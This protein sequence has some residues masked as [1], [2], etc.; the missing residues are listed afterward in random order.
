MAGKNEK[1]VVDAVHAAILELVNNCI[2]GTKVKE[3]VFITIIGYGNPKDVS[4]IKKGWASDYAR[5]LQ[6]CKENGT[7]IIEPESYGGTPMDLGFQKAAECIEKWLEDRQSAGGDIPAP[8]VINITDGMPNSNED[9]TRE[10][11]KLMNMST[12]DGNVIVFNIHMDEYS[13]NEIRFPSTPADAGDSE[14]AQF[15][16]D[17]SSEM[18]DQFVRVA[19]SKGFEGVCRGAKGFIANANGDTLVRFIEFGSS[20]STLTPR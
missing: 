4:I 11:K 5:D 16:F 2:S 15:L 13:N 14:E 19:K 6:K 8:I 1:K 17:I 3:R 20:V 18:T 7:R 12:P 9:A 10:A